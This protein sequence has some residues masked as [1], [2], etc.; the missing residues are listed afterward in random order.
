M[1]K[2][3][4]D[5]E[6]IDERAAILNRISEILIA[7]N[8]INNFNG[9]LAI[10]SATGSAGVHRLKF[11]FQRLTE[12][13]RKALEDSRPDDHFKKYQ[14]KLRSINP[15]CVPFLGMYLTNILHIEEGN[16]DFLPNTELINF[17]KRRKVAEITGEIQ[18]YQ[19]Q[20][21]CYA[22]ERRIRHF[23]ENLNPFPDMNDTE[24]SNYIYTKSLDLEPREAKAPTKYP[25]KWP[26]LSLKSPGIKSKVIKNTASAVTSVITSMNPTK[27]DESRSSSSS[28][29][30]LTESSK[31][32]NDF[33]VFAQ[34]RTIFINFFKFL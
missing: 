18:Q 12:Q 31:F 16:P 30:T 6:N 34:V 17:F 27:S 33:S 15:P 13:N 8:E 29:S 23:L 32:E 19:N 10:V 22:V 3:I 28:N 14:E 5:A 2:N 26:H 21:Y 20:P 4:V 24:I 7:L 11:T 9:V 25:R 1:E